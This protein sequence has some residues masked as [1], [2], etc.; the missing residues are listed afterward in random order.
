MRFRVIRLRG[1]IGN[2]LFILCEVI[3]RLKLG[4]C[5][6]VDENTGFVKDKYRRSSILEHLNIKFS[7]LPMVLCNCLLAIDRF[8]LNVL[9]RSIYLNGYFQF[10]MGDD[11]VERV[12]AA[13]NVK[14]YNEDLTRHCALLHFR[15]YKGLSEDHSNLRIDY[16]A[17]AIECFKQKGIT[18]F[19]VAGE[20]DAILS[21]EELQVLVGDCTIRLL[22]FKGYSDLEE[23]LY[24][25]SYKDIAISNSTYAWW[26]ARFST[27]KNSPV[28][29][30]M[31]SEKH[32][33][34][35]HSWNVNAL[36]HTNWNVL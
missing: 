7:L 29:I 4:E 8:F 34:I 16:Y 20:N 30:Y 23:L 31:P 22:D 26:I 24:L 10:Q 1:G 6:Y 12:M 32:L 15:D 17:K 36:C 25:S 9:N 18:S 35:S 28:T 27:I 33:P 11:V 5:I 14:E 21:E 2:Q 13:F 3:K 19:H